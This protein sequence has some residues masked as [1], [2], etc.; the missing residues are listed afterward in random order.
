MTRRR[1]V[2][3]AS[4]LALTLAACGGGG[5]S[6]DDVDAGATNPPAETTVPDTAPPGAATD[7][8]APVPTGE[9]PLPQVE[10]R[11]VA[12]GEMLQL[13]A[14][15]PSDRPLLVWFWAPH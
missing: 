1:P 12:T 10:V 15:L 14:L 3:A 8:T 7:T 13:A 5:E 4:V 6:D 11:D 9:S 2:L